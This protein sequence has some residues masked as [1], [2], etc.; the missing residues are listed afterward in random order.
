ME[1]WVT[2]LAGVLVGTGVGALAAGIL[3]RVAARPARPDAG[4]VLAEIA[5]ITA[6]DEPFAVLAGVV[7]E[8]ARLALALDRVAVCS[9]SADGC[10]EVPWAT[11]G[12][13]P[14]EPEAG[15]RFAIRAGDD[16]MGFLRV[17][18]A[19]AAAAGVLPWIAL[20]LAP[21]L[22]RELGRVASKRAAD[23]DDLTGLSNRRAFRTM[24]GHAIALA[25]SRGRP[26]ALTY[27]DLNGFKRIND[28]LGHLAGDAVLKA[29][30]RRIASAVRHSDSVLRSGPDTS[31][32]SRLGGDEFTVIL[33]EVDSGEGAEV[34]A[35]RILEALAHPLT[36]EDTE[37]FVGA[38]IG[39]AVY[40]DDAENM[41]ELIRCADTAMY[42]AK[43]SGSSTYRRFAVHDREADPLA[44]EADLRAALR[45]GDVGVHYQPILSGEGG[46]LVGAEA[47]LRWTHPTHGTVPPA[48]FVPLAERVGLI[49][50]LS[51]LVLEETL[52]WLEREVERL[53]P[54]FRVSINVAP[55]Q[56]EDPVFLH[57]VV[58][59]LAQSPLPNRV[60]EIEV[61]ESALMADSDEIR[62]IIRAFASLGVG[63]ALDDFGT[64]YS[65]LSLLKRMPISRIKIDRCFV[66]RLPDQP[67][68][69]AI[70]SAILG[71]ADS[72]GLPVVAEG[73]ENEEQQEFLSLGGCAEL[74]GWLFARAMPLDRFL[75]W[76]ES[77]GAIPSDP[78]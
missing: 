63:F 62:E 1:P 37:V 50:T 64:G 69:V 67:E 52:G 2:A 17:E 36:V 71:M 34:V 9:L 23:I 14:G 7:A 13:D 26:L 45:E 28:S 5:A 25:R 38:S 75:A 3:R 46:N 74:Q 59:R 20:A 54:G 16:T 53:P 41:E 60:L 61:T 18:G 40:P 70:V 29:V 15:T 19:D 78:R 73:V 58:R 32:V 72:L 11:S 51:E 27:V 39:V 4:S 48:A 43:R 55:R 56:L 49:G 8:H 31:G 10:R 6:R 42:A 35:R 12:A 44:L 68:D 66:E 21:P 22:C 30:A 47:L 76:A 65:S 57:K 24:L 33:D 77:R